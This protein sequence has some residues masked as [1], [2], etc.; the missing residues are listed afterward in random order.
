MTF[1]PNASPF[2]GVDTNALLFFLRNAAPVDSFFWGRVEEAWSADLTNWTISD[3]QEPP[4][5]TLFVQK[6]TLSEGIRNGAFPSAM[7]C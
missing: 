5:A 3:F 1:A 6:R 7:R 2:P 4:G